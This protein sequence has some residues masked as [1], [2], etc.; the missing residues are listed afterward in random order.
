MGM[1]VSVPRYSVEDLERFDDDGNRYELLDGLLLV[2]SGP[3]PAHQSVAMNLSPIL[4]N[5]VRP[6]GL[7]K[8]FAPGAVAYPPFTHL[9]PDLLV[10]PSRFGA[11][12]AWPEITEHWLAVEIF[13]RSSRRYDRDFKR[14]AY[15]A[16]GVREVWLVDSFAG[17]IEVCREQGSGRLAEETLAWQVPGTDLTV[18]IDLQAVFA[19]LR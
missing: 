15:L 14:D 11:D 13:S 12:A 8:V 5:A 10:V 9:L 3:S 19:G 6:R 17:T 4:W 7:G 18:T 1:A 2:T 16:L